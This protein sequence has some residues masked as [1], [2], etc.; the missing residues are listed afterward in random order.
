MAAM[1]APSNSAMDM[2]EALEGIPLLATSA[3]SLLRVVPDATLLIWTE[4]GAR[5]A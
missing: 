5:T 2:W 3:V 4:P 1:N